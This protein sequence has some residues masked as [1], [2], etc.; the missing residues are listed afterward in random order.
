M[1]SV[2]VGDQNAVKVIDGHFNGGE[3]RQSFAFA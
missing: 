1:I 2:F 3:P